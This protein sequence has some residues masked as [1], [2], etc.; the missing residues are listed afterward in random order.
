MG[1]VRGLAPA[2]TVRSKNR[3]VPAALVATAAVASEE[4]T[5]AAARPL[6]V[7]SIRRVVDLV[8][9]GQSGGST[10]VTPGAAA[11]ARRA[12]NNTA[13]TDLTIPS[14][15]TYAVSRYDTTARGVTRRVG[16]LF[17]CGASPASGR[18]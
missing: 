9:A 17:A 7:T 14:L 16:R 1:Y 15:Q 12:N 18:A 11:A 4:R 5:V 10:L 13:K 8:T 6:P 2:G 3:W